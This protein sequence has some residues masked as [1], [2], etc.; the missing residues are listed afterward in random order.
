MSTAREALRDADEYLRRAKQAQTVADE[1]MMRRVRSSDAPPWRLS[2]NGFTSGIHRFDSASADVSI[3]LLD[4][5]QT[6][7]RRLAEENRDYAAAIE[8]RVQ[9]V[10]P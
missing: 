2:R 10:E 9:V 6:L 1:I 3:Y 8:A 5:I 4:E 7:C